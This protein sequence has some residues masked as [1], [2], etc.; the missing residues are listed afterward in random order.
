M[1]DKPKPQ[2]QPKDLKESYDAYQ[3]LRLS[4]KLKNQDANARLN[5]LKSDKRK[6]ILSTKPKIKKSKK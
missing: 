6:K 5:A 4:G 1:G 2:K 3:K